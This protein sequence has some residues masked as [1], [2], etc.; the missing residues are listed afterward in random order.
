LARGLST[1]RLWALSEDAELLRGGL[2]RGERPDRRRRQRLK[3]LGSLG[4]QLLLLCGSAW[5]VVLFKRNGVRFLLCAGTVLAGMLVK[6]HAHVSLPT[7]LLSPCKTGAL[8]P[9]PDPW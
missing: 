7:G 4:M 6:G 1:Y 5:V 3:K 9:T 8:A 2:V